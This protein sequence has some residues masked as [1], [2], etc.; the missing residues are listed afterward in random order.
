M[1]RLQRRALLSG[2]ADSLRQK[3]SWC[4]ETH[5]QKATYFLQK[6]KKVPA[7]FD[8]FLYKHGPFSF[9]LRDELTAM[10][11]DGLLDLRA[12]WPYGPSLI[13]TEE[14]AELRE[15]Y[16]RTMQKYK[17]QLQFVADQLRNR[18]VSELEKLATALYLT[19][20]ESQ[21][22]VSQR[23]KRLHA[24]KPHVTVDDAAKAVQEIDEIVKVS[25]AS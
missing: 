25:K 17:K 6:L 23:A 13:P 18:N 21:R 3:G 5:L 2:L 9:D 8:F 14:S 22:S 20:E 19:M 4:G 12:Q 1:D 16:S 10:R 11:S 15:Q 7:G 24:L